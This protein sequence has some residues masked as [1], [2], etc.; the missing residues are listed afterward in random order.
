MF[1]FEKNFGL[2]MGKLSDNRFH[3]HYAIQI[4]ISLHPEMILSV[5]NE[6]EVIGNA[7]LIPAKQEHKLISQTNQ[8]TMLINPLSAIG[9]QLHLQFGNSKDAILENELSISCIE[10]LK[11]F[12][13]K[14]ITFENLCR[15]ISET[16]TKYRSTHEQK[17]QREED[18]ISKAIDF[19]DANFERVVPLEEVATYCFL[20]PSR[21][22]HLFKEKTNL[23]FRR[24]QL[25][26]RVVKSLPSLQK[27]SIT[28]TAH[29]FGFSDSSHYTRTFIETFG[30]TPKFFLPKE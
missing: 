17:K 13:K 6:K 12:E 4:S 21:F 5:A 11:A 3:K 26:N 20:S 15:L 22:L 1:Y 10:A 24:Y 7:F 29:A 2:F 23:N 19:L 28:E 30:V 14:A 16:L 18:R 8:I 25:W 9:H 27:S